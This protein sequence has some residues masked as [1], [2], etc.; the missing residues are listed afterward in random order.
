MAAVEI[1]KADPSLTI[2]EKRQKVGYLLGLKKKRAPKS[3]NA[4]ENTLLRK[5]RSK[6]K[7]YLINQEFEALGL[8]TKRVKLTP[9]Q[10]LQH[11]L[12]RRSKNKTQKANLKRFAFDHPDL[13]KDYGIDVDRIG[14][15]LKRK[16]KAPKK[17]PKKTKNKKNK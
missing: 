11:K 13:A 4:A 17:A 14:K 12:D 2:R 8:K 16:P 3:G 5:N 9:E 10:K 7:R 15:A 1:V 6:I